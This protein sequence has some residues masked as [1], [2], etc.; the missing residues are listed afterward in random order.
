MRRKSEISNKKRILVALLM[1][2]PQGAVIILT[3]WLLEKEITERFLWISVLVAITMVGFW[4]IIAPYV[5]GKRANK[6]K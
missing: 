4:I 3:S 5:F 1:G 2:L 6:R